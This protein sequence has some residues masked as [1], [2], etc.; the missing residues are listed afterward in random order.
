VRGCGYCFFRV[1]RFGAVS[2]WVG[3]GT[4]W[5]LTVRGK[6]GKGAGGEGWLLLFWSGWVCGGVRVL[7]FCDEKS[8]L[9]IG[10][11]PVLDCRTQE[12]R[13]ACDGQ[14][15]TRK[16][17]EGCLAFDG[18]GAGRERRPETVSAYCACAEQAGSGTGVTVVRGR[19][20]PC[21]CGLW[22]GGT[23][24]CVSLGVFFFGGGEG[25]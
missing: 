14:G 5:K 16:T 8:E 17:R 13:K 15:F 1:K 3:S 9:W 18:V 21:R 24:G 7:C 10:F 19:G 22:S 2:R 20:L 25:W 6:R 11:C 4:L 23:S 12:A